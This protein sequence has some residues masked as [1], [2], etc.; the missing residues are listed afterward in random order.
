MRIHTDSETWIKHFLF[1]SGENHV[2]LLNDLS[3]HEVELFYRYGGDS[4]FMKM[5]M[6]VDAMRRVGVQS[7]SL[8]I[9]YFPGARQDRVC[10]TGE[11]LSAAF[12]ANL[13][14]QQG[15]KKVIMFDA[16]SDVVPALVNN[17]CAL[18][19]HAYV[20]SCLNGEVVTLISPDA[21][22]NKKVFSLSRHLGGLEVVRADKKRDVTNGAIIGTDVFAD[23]LTGKH[24]VIVDDIISGG[25]TFIELAKKLKEKNAG[26]ISL[27]VSHNEGVAVKEILEESGISQVFSTD[28][29]SGSCITPSSFNHI[30]DI[31]K[32]IP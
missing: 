27:I 18:N 9:P 21:G 20:A 12:Y 1:K 16:H 22:A 5:L 19:N 23:D 31:S 4:S 29:L 28:S 6:L 24:C 32:I 2:Q 15:F 10:N 3:G 25:R 13:I 7:L 11:C 8:T 30:T 14:N 26:K 17:V